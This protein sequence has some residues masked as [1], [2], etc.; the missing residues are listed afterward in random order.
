MKQK[1]IP[2]VNDLG[3]TDPMNTICDLKWNYPIFNM[4]RGEFRSCCRT[5]SRKVSVQELEALGT[6]AFL[7]SSHQLQSRLDLVNG[8]RHKDCQSCWNLEDS[9]MQSPR[10]RPEQ[11]WHHMQTRKQI[12]KSIRFSN[13]A[14]RIELDK[15]NSIDHPSLK[16]K[17]PYMLEISLGNTCDMKCMYC[18]H[19]YSTQW[20]TERIKYGEITQEQYEKEFPKASEKFE[21]TFW[22]WFDTVSIHLGRLGIIGGEPLIMPE[23]YTFVDKLIES[24]KKV[25]PQRKEK[26]TFWIVTNLNTPPKY[27]EK[28]FN[29]LPTLT[30]MFNVE[31]LVSM[32]AVGPRAEYIRNGIDWDKFSSNLDL[33]LSNK[34]LKFNFGF[35]S[36]VNALSIA[37]TEEFVRWVEALY[38]KYGRPIAIKHNIVSFPSWQKPLTLTADFA[39]YLYK[40]TE[41][42]KTRVDVMPIVDDYYGRWDQYIIFLENLAASIKNNNRDETKDRQKFVEWFNTYDERRK[43][44]LLE[45]F[46]EY[47]TFFNMCKSL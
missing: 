7:N 30:E 36:S 37:S 19:H 22:K 20:A 25:Q 23:F 10:H 35:I 6:D 32:E 11:F 46:P 40:C 31:I 16:S 29:Y 28:L 39:D 38:F 41:Y 24:I 9:G 47:Q 5:P 18:S 3:Q 34:E 44:N 2:I 15:I 14:L 33:L 27:L 43:L 42:M 17:Y 26:M 45:V 8:I 4:D 13:D 1:I 21:N 12:D